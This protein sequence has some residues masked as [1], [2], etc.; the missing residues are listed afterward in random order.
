[1][2]KRLICLTAFVLVL[3][4]AAQA[5]DPN[6]VGH[7]KFDGDSGTN[8]IDY[9]D[10]NNHGTIHGGASLD[11]S[12][13]LT[14]DGDD[15]YVS[16][17]IGSVVASLT[18][19]T[20][21]V[22][23]DFSNSGGSWQRIF[24]FGS[25]T[26]VNM[27]LTP[28]TGTAG[29]M[30]F[31]ITTSGAG[32]EQ[33][34]TAPDTLPSGL[35]LVVL[36]IDADNDVM[37]LYLNEDSVA[38]NPSA[39]LTPSSLGS[40]SN[41]WL[42]R[43]QYSADGYFDGSYDEFRI[44]DYALN[45]IE[46]LGL[47]RTE[48]TIAW[49]PTPADG[50]ASVNPE[51]D[52][53]WLPGDFAADV[54]GHEL[55]YGTDFDDVT[56]ATRTS[57]PDVN[58]VLLTDTTYEPGTLTEGQTYYW[59]V[60]EVNG[61][62]TW[63]GDVWSF[64]V[65]NFSFAD[66]FDTAHN[67]LTQGVASTGWDGFIG[68]GAGETV[69]ALNSSM[70]R[71][72]KLYMESTGARWEPDFDPLG[73]F[74]YK[75]VEGDFSVK[76]K[77]DES[78]DVEWNDVGIMARVPDLA[79]AGSGEDFECVD[80]F[81]SIGQNMVRA[82]DNG[83]EIETSAG[84][85]MPY[86]RLRRVGSTF[87]HEASD[88]GTEWTPLSGSPRTRTDMAGLALQVGLQHA[89]YNSNTGYVVYEDFAIEIFPPNPYA[90]NPYPQDSQ[91]MVPLDADLTW[92]PGF[93]AESHDIYFGTDF[94]DVN[95]ANNSWPI[96][97]IYQG[98]V[99]FSTLSF[100]PPTLQENQVYYWRIDEV[101]SDQIWKGPVWTFRGFSFFIDDFE[102]YVDSSDLL[103][104]WQ[105]VENASLSLTTTEVH[106]GQNAMQLDY[107][108]SA[109]DYY[110]AAVLD[111]HSATDWVEQS[112]KSISL[113][114][115]GNQ[116]NQPD[117]LSVILEDGDWIPSTSV[118]EYDGDPNDLLKEYWQRWDI[119]VSSFIESN[120]DFRLTDVTKLT[121]VIGDI[122]GQSPGGSGTI[123][124]D[125][126]A[127]KQIR[128]VDKNRPIA[129]FDGDCDVDIDDLKHLAQQ[130]LETDS[131]AD[132]IED[133]STDSKDY[134]ALADKW[135]GE[136]SN[137]P[138]PLDID[139]F[140]TPVP[141]TDVDITGGLWAERME[142]DRTITI[143][144]IMQ[145]LEDERR[146]DNLRIAAGLMT[147]S[148]YG[149]V[150][151]DSDVYKTIEA[152]GYSLK[153]HPD[154]A[155]EATVD[156]I[157]DIVEAAQWE[158]GY[159][160]SYYTITNP[161]ARWTNIANNHELYCAGHLFEGAVAYYEAT[162]KD[163][164]LNVSI[165]FI[166][167]ILDEFGPGK[168]MHPP[169]HQE[170]ELAL[171]KM[172]HLLGDERY[173]DLAKFFIDERGNAEG[174]SLYGTYS[175]DHKPLVEQ[176]NGVGHAV[177][178][179]YFFHGA[180]D[181]AR[182]KLDQDYMKAMKRVW[183]NIVSA[184]TY[185][186]GGLGQPGGPEGFTVD[187]ALG[188][189]SYCE[190]CA[191][192]AFSDW[193]HRMFLL[194]GD[195]RYL[196]M[197]ER[198]MLN[199]ILSGLSLSGDRFFY[200]NRLESGGTTRPDWY[201][202][203]CCPPNLAQYIMS[204]G[205]KAYAHNDE[206]IYVNTYIE[207]DAQIPLAVNTVNVSVDTNYPWDGDIEITV[208]PAQ[209]ASFPIYLRIPGWARNVPMPGNL[210]GYLDESTEQVTLE[211]NGSPVD[212]NIEKGFAKIER[213]WTAGD[214]IHLVLPMPVRKVIAHPL[215]TADVGLV[216]IQRGPVV[217][218]AEGVDNG[219]SVSGISVPDSLEFTATYE[220]GTLNGVTVL[221]STSPSITLVPYYTW[222]NR[223]STPMKVWLPREP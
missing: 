124:I 16:L 171:V 79:D 201:E 178:A 214:T 136:Y 183:D 73:P 70:D 60:D 123:Y 77:V 167:H 30:R 129:D 137:W 41:N 39:T 58:Y 50:A 198:S 40:T 220:P 78:S 56:N 102:S 67:Y 111:F 182:E 61:L 166:E 25:N 190:T 17:P 43:S 142:T 158:D 66:S 174:H 135:Q 71:A 82:V 207:G 24:D 10:N 83:S 143:P 26:T 163:K 88:D 162:G 195:G 172:Y 19:C 164:I 100:S 115:K 94:N 109:G 44:Y 203:A 155:L 5:A 18:N 221:R 138:V 139:N 204:I 173:L 85:F 219:G 8:V 156:D 149:Y 21:A 215:V 145:K 51:S 65:F 152:V 6:I 186:I 128:C 45:E 151:N 72:G 53:S 22:W 28:R 154:P 81:I 146:I 157:I 216:V 47:T 217:Y 2:G 153:L 54:N 75:I 130:W 14:L 23:V 200:P 122:T 69:N 114:F 144:H 4:L 55:Y 206:G 68:L 62:D 110:S 177:R 29:P 188:N 48:K 101:G 179:C 32:G 105:P 49:Y 118:I 147:G 11:G 134:A 223:G 106:D 46:I 202:C 168:N 107:D 159:L 36:T 38:S 181:V 31:A 113:Y 42:G 27:F 185:I 140:L 196:D 86:L 7:W 15:D 170:V 112:A 87:Y 116:S 193:N 184:K 98:N 175:Q 211:V 108:N 131:D 205:E 121:F 120:P 165:N 199:N 95:D 208:T 117:T 57:H 9:S 37:T 74:L 59:R 176:E 90:S 148:Y 141:F 189:N 197:M 132:I 99:P 161:G 212:I 12:G 84:V 93:W 210:Y 91:I 33:Q 76:V 96:G 13:Q 126:I 97:T 160:N 150:F 64:T 119:D 133:G 34:A 222:A 191:S 80:H 3:G 169:G 52:L 35:Q 20:F 127:L 89:N 218:C 213:L 194:T 103:S 92:E 209:A 192:I 1:M 63:E 180:A 187:Y 104:E 125:D